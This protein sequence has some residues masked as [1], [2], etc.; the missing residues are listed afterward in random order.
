MAAA[1]QPTDIGLYL[2]GKAVNDTRF[3]RAAGTFFRMAREVTSEVAG[4]RSAVD[5]LVRVAGGSIDLGGVGVAKKASGAAYAALVAGALVAGFQAFEANGERPEHFNDEALRLARDLAA[6]RGPSMAVV[7][8]RGGGRTVPLTAQT[9]ATVERLLAPAVETHGTLEGMLE[10]I[11][12][13]AQPYGVLYDQLTG[14][15]VRCEFKKEAMRAAWACGGQ[16]VAVTGMVK[17]RANGVPVSI[18]AE[19]VKSL[20]EKDIPS[21]LDVRG[22]LG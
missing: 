20:E 19:D 18:D 13:H 16:R 12:D 10:T 3:L 21:Y 14:A 11:S 4:S 22:I 1:R 15:G 2:D 8:V 17:Y 5:W 7:E 9:V 6:M